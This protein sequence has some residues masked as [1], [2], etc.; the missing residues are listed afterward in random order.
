M[1]EIAVLMLMGAVLAA[2]A[3][4]RRFGI[5]DERARANIDAMRWREFLDGAVLGTNEDGEVCLG[6]S[7]GDQ[8]DWRKD[9]PSLMAELDNDA[10]HRASAIVGFF[11]HVQRELA[12]SPEVAS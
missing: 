2:F 6:T 4:G 8:E 1:P 12:A 9:F 5:E 7:F 3:A 10:V 11:D